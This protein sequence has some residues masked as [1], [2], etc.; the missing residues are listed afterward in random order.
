[1]LLPTLMASLALAAGGTGHARLTLGPI[2]VGEASVMVT[3]SVALPRGAARSRTVVAFTLAPTGSTRGRSESFT[4]R[5]DAGDRFSAT[6][7]SSLIG[8][9]RL[10]ARV[11]IG[12]RPSGPAVTRTVGLLGPPRYVACQPIP[13][14]PPAAGQGV[15]AGGIYTVGGPAPGIDECTAGTVTVSTPG[16]TVVASAT[17]TDTQSYAIVVPVG[18]YVVTATTPQGLRCFANGEQP[19]S[20]TSQVVADANTACSVP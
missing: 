9:L 12:G 5:L 17:V 1:M 20:V 7:S 19:I 2:S 15:L 4:V 18:S 10:R 6:L 14:P 3:G 13:V 11:E 16:G 8:A